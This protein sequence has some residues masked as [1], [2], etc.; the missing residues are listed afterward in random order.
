MSGTGQEGLLSELP[1]LQNK[2]KRDPEAYR[3]EFELQYR[4]YQTEYQIFSLTPSRSSTSFGA[5]V[6]FMGHVAASYPAEM[7][8]F[9]AQI[10][11]L[12]EKHCSVLDPDLRKTLVKTLI[13]VRNRGLLE[14]KD[15]L[16][17]FFQLFRCEDKK[18]RELMFT[19]IVADITNMNKLHVNMKLNR[20]LQNFMYTML[21]SDSEIAAK[22]SIEVMVELYRKRVWNDARTVNVIASAC[23]SKITKVMVA[24]V[25][26]FL[27]IEVKM[28]NDMTAEDDALGEDIVVDMHKGAKKTIKREKD[29]KKGKMKKKKA[30]AKKNEEKTNGLF[31][32]IAMLNDPQTL[33]E[34]L[35]R[36]VKKSNERFEVKM[37]LFNL[38]S[39]LVGQHQLL[40]LPFYHHIQRYLV[41]HQA[42]VTQILAYLVQAC[43]P[44]VPP[45][46]LQPVVRSI[47]NNF[48]VDRVSEEVLAVGMN[49]VSQIVTRVPL[50][51]EGEE[52]E[53][54]I[55][56][57]V[58]RASSK[59]KSVMIA[60]RS[61]LNLLREINPKL[62]KKRQRGKYHNPDAAPARY[63][64]VHASEEIDG[65]ELLQ[66]AEDEG[67]DMDELDE[68]AEE[69]SDSDEG[70]WENVS[71]EGEGGDDA[72]DEGEEGDGWEVE[73]GGE[74]EEEVEDSRQD[75]TKRIE[76]NRILSSEDFARIRMLK[77]ENL[78]AM[79]DPK[80]RKVLLARKKERETTSTI[81][82]AISK[83]SFSAPTTVAPE[84]LMGEQKKK[85]MSLIKRLEMIA[86]KQGK[87]TGGKDRSA[88][89]STNT[90]KARKKNF[91][92]LQK[93]HR[94]QYKTTM[95]WKKNGSAKRGG[96]MSQ[97]KIIMNHDNKKRRRKT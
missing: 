90:E 36:V 46:E 1:L 75:P 9:P 72:M 71:D 62:L 92:M 16:C 63:G 41:S 70:D 4:H 7:K 93:S 42:Q 25:Q 82:R 77:E 28:E 74:E 84:D 65:A 11:E 80:Q 52:M 58:D 44:L 59:N 32:A 2:L 43:H 78:A 15:L 48:I 79:K 35:F 26:F 6:T 87:F 18:L 17:L 38:I 76:Y 81:S 31:P 86:E 21:T 13:L 83:A 85:R 66:Q 61:F 68:M 91:L 94:V 8:G 50:V 96:H 45:E 14:P 5:L 3:E 56:D 47:A 54:L 10:S 33:A 67:R 49:S 57:L 19:H 69:D 73:E 39:R 23:T 97:Q 95:S 60:A 37:L 27:G 53:P 22:K 55:E 40:L 89:G 12:L 88:S 34:K 30:M 24:A 64:E 20:Q 51:M 29:T